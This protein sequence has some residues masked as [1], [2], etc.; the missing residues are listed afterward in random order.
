MFEEKRVDAGE[1]LYPD[2]FEI[3]FGVVDKVLD[4][5]ERVDGD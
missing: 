2:L 3:E 4:G 1:A 5:V